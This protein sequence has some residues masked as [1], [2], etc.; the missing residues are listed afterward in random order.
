[1]EVSEAGRPR[2]V[3]E[4]L[5]AQIELIT[6]ETEVLPGVRALAAPGHTPGQLAFW[7]ESG[8]SRMLY[9][10]DAIAHPI[11]L[12]Y[13]DWNIKADSDRGQAIATR[14]YLLARAIA[15]GARLFVYHFPFPGLYR[16]A[17]DGEGWRAEPD[18]A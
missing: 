5:H 7:I 8:L 16:L 11:H 3:L 6:P 13:P 14:T 18:S 10:A 1:M 9:T 17:R 12:E 15:E 4:R 2:A